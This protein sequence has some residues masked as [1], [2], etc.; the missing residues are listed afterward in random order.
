MNALLEVEPGLLSIIYNSCDAITRLLLAH[1]CTLFSV[2]EDRKVWRKDVF[3]SPVARLVSVPMGEGVLCLATFIDS[4]AVLHYLIVDCK[5]SHNS[6]RC[7]FLAATHGCTESLSFFYK[8]GVKLS[9]SSSLVY[10]N[11]KTLRWLVDNG[12]IEIDIDLYCDIVSQDC[13]DSLKYLVEEKGV[14][15]QL[16]RSRAR[17]RT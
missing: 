8:R 4:S 5:W 11:V 2:I 10:K 9:T 15:P 12:E 13:V 3:A 14:V 17:T 16:D 7:V 1:T 6:S